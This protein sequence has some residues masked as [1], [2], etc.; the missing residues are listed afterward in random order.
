[1]SANTA[2]VILSRIYTKKDDEDWSGVWVPGEHTDPRDASIFDD[3]EIKEIGSF[4][5]ARNFDGYLKHSHAYVGE[6]SLVFDVHFELPEQAKAYYKACR[7]IANTS[8]LYSI[9]N[10]K[11]AENSIPDYQ[12]Y[13]SLRN[14]VTKAGYPLNDKE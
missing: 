7:A 6:N 12:V 1:M 3:D 11:K 10:D 9:I 2:T 13:W 5:D 14:S 4:N 8:P